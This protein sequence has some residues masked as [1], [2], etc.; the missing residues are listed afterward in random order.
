M[1]NRAAEEACLNRAIELALKQRGWTKKFA[2]SL[3]AGLQDGLKKVDKDRPDFVVLCPPMENGKKA[4]IGIEHFRVD[5]HVIQKKT[6]AVASTAVVEQRRVDEFYDEHRDR[7]LK[8]H[9]APQK[10][11]DGLAEL[12][13]NQ[14]DVEQKATYSNF[15]ASFEYGLEKHIKHVDAYWKN[16]NDIR[17]NNDIKL[18][19]LIEIHGN[20]DD[21]YLWRGGKTRKAIRGRTPIFDDIV[22][23]IEK[24]VDTKR[25]SFVILYFVE[26][27]DTKKDRVVVVQTKAIRE[28]LKKQNEFVYKY[29]GKDFRLKPFELPYSKSES[30]VICKVDET[31]SNKLEISMTLEKTPMQDEEADLLA[32]MYRAL[33]YEKKGIPYATTG[34]VF[35]GIEYLRDAVIYW[36]KLNFPGKEWMVYPILKHESR[37]MQDERYK[38]FKKR[39]G[40]GE[41][42]D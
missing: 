8:T 41:H 17:G 38:A 24:K 19:F 26:T 32:A 10:T 1:G 31:D 18:G 33:E 22:N 29:A 9:Q 39:W 14:V 23:L 40:K 11:L 5:A 42:N 25:F 16:L 28:Y 6:N 3:Q 30:N 37:E 13:K 34:E 35:A 12:L 36:K 15:V 21:L 4:L 7:V 27:L 20:F 2:K